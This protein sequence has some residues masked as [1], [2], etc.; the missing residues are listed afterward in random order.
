MIREAVLHIVT[1][2]FVLR[3]STIAF[4][5]TDAQVP[6]K[7]GAVSPPPYASQSVKRDVLTARPLRASNK[8]DLDKYIFGGQQFGSNR[9]RLKSSKS[10]SLNVLV[11]VDEERIVLFTSRNKLLLPF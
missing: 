4:P 3:K 7:T 10:S 8:P 1:I 9:E 6:R 2:Y 11:N 5:W